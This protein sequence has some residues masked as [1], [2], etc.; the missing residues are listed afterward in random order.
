MLFR[1]SKRQ[2]AAWKLI[3]YLSEPDVQVRFHGLTGNL[4]PRRAAW[5][6]PALADD[7]YARAFRDQLERARPAPKVPEWERIA[8]EIKLVG[9]QLANGRVNVDQAAEELDR[10]ADRIL[11]KRR[12]MLD[13][14]TLKPTQAP[15][16]GNKEGG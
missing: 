15:V 16:A 4:P 12:W 5:T 3:S 7:V 2:D 10:R 14:Q 1:S 13:H 9:E 6:T 8:T 11:E